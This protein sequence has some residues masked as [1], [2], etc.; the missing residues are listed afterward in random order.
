MSARQPNQPQAAS[1][2]YSAGF[3]PVSVPSRACGRAGRPSQRRAPGNNE[4]T[5][6]RTSTC[7]DTPPSL[8]LDP[9]MDRVGERR[10]NEESA[11]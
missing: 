7:K 10:V 4:T 3:G 6:L 5:S 11:S 2:R 8:S 9:Q 1:V